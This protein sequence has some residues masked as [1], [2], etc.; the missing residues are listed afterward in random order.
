MDSSKNI[1][2]VLW[3]GLKTNPTHSAG[4]T[5][6]LK[7]CRCVC[8]GLLSRSTSSLAVMQDGDVND[9]IA[10]LEGGADPCVRL[11][12]WD[13]MT[14]LHAC[15]MTGSEQMMR[16]LYV[17][18]PSKPHLSFRSYIKDTQRPI[19]YSNS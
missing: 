19:R 6:Y 9:T 11:K 15:A 16:A 18:D 1:M 14:A 10:L 3:K 5:H 12:D 4:Q 2:I 7:L 13:Y 17:S 8:G